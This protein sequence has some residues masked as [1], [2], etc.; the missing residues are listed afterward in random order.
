MEQQQQ[1]IDL[2]QI[3]NN[4]DNEYELNHD[5]KYSAH[6]LLSGDYNHN[7]TIHNNNIS[8]SINDNQ[9]NNNNRNSN[10]NS[11]LLKSGT[12]QLYDRNTINSL[13]TIKQQNNLFKQYNQQLYNE[14]AIQKHI[15][16]LEQQQ[17]IRTQ[18]ELHNQRIY[19]NNV[20][21][22]YNNSLLDKTKPYDVTRDQIQQHNYETIQQ[23][24][25]D[26]S[27][28]TA[29]KHTLKQYI[30][31]Q[32]LKQL[33][34]K[35]VEYYSNI[36]KP[37]TVDNTIK[38]KKAYEYNKTNK[39]L[40]KTHNNIIHQFTQCQISI[41]RHLKNENIAQMKKQYKDNM[42]HNVNTF[43]QQLQQSRD[44]YNLYKYTTYKQKQYNVLDSKYT[45]QQ[46][47]AQNDINKQHMLQQQYN[48]KMLQHNIDN[49]IKQA[50]QPL[51]NEISNYKQQQYIDSIDLNSI[52][53]QSNID[54]NNDVLYENYIGKYKIDDLHNL[55][56]LS[57]NELEQQI[58][59][60]KNLAVQIKQQY[61]NNIQQQN[62]IQYE[63]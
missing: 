58:Y 29:Q 8:D 36:D 53:Q 45:L 28:Y 1:I 59:V 34:N 37:K 10:N 19:I 18:K 32:H 38:V 23:R 54:M 9:S 57:D 14:L 44:N 22:Q 41:E 20:Q 27:I 61:T 60:L 62:N 43:K 11:I 3:N 49:I 40:S 21:Q 25:L 2:T 33:H 46:Q 16:L 7:S 42:K 17:K 50:I 6:L 48:N 12:T 30:K 26:N 47:R 24:K 31:I 55:E 35:D 39:Q 52:I 51:K 15:E 56:L 4:N 5:D 13:D 63:R